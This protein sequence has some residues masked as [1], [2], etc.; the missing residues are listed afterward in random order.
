MFTPWKDLLWHRSVEAPIRSNLVVAIG[1]LAFRFPNVLEPWTQNIYR[2]LSD[3]DKGVY[4]ATIVQVQP[5]LWSVLP[6]RSWSSVSCFNSNY[7]D[8]ACSRYQQEQSKVLDYLIQI[9]CRQLRL[10]FV[11]SN[12][13]RLKKIRRLHHYLV[14]VPQT[15]RCQKRNRIVQRRNR[16]VT[17]GLQPWS[18]AEFTQC[19]D[20]I[21]ILFKT[22]FTIT[23]NDCYE[24]RPRS[25]KWSNQ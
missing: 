17:L 5:E 20:T 2:P 16:I 7:L 13:G 10:V 18:R 21:V 22:N 4:N 24:N 23:V 14:K 12:N 11:V 9:C 19:H 1:D 6:P 15:F 25:P 8:L 3:P